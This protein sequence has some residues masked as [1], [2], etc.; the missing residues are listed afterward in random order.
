MTPF[1]REGRS[2]FESMQRPAATAQPEMI[3]EN[4]FQG[5]EDEHDLKDLLIELGLATDEVSVSREDAQAI[6][7]RANKA[8]EG[9]ED[10]MAL[11]F[12]YLDRMAALKPDQFPNLSEIDPAVITQMLAAKG[13][14]ATPEEVAGMLTFGKTGV[15]KY[16][17][18]GVVDK[19][20]EMRMQVTE[21]IKPVSG[22]IA[23]S[24][25]I[26]VRGEDVSDAELLMD[27]Q[28]PH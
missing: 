17:D 23:G 1:P 15:W 16:G 20:L 22:V 9:I 13:V 14:N 26:D 24:E 3:N 19:W 6:L 28:R 7:I 2:A 5:I 21:G 12:A 4:R 27:Q 10:D 8:Y 25:V 11:S 18:N